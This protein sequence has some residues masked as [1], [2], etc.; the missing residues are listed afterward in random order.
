MNS[1][2]NRHLDRS[3]EQAIYELTLKKQRSKK[4]TISRKQMERMQQLASELMPQRKDL[5]DLISDYSAGACANQPA[6]A[7]GSG[8]TAGQTDRRQHLHDLCG[9]EA[10]LVLASHRQKQEASGGQQSEQHSTTDC[11]NTNNELQRQS[12]TSTIATNSTSAS[13]SPSSGAHTHASSCLTTADET[14][15]RVGQMRLEHLN[16]ELKRRLNQYEY[17]VAQEKAILGAY[18]MALIANEGV[19]NFDNHHNLKVV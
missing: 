13:S 17:L 2:V 7:A 12:S 4:S 14:S 9:C 3:Q 16:Q 1:I 11:A 10:S 18:N 8:D 19:N 15:I 6:G 5:A